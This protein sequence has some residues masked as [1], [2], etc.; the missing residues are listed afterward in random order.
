MFHNGTLRYLPSIVLTSSSSSGSTCQPVFRRTISTRKE[1]AVSMPATRIGHEWAPSCLLF[2]RKGSRLRPDI[3]QHH[4]A[5][6]D[7]TLVT[8]GISI[9]VNLAI[10]S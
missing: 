6:N 10:T 2:G 4:L 9:S 3:A 7:Q 5:L 1:R 8:C